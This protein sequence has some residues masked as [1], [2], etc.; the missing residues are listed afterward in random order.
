MDDGLGH[1]R[2]DR[3]P[4]QLIVTRQ[5]LA[6]GESEDFQEIEF[7]DDAQHLSIFDHGEGIEIVSVEER[8][9]SRMVVWRIT[10]FTVRVIYCSAVA[11]RKRYM[12]RDAPL[13]VGYSDFRR[14]LRNVALSIACSHLYRCVVQA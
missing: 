12:M 1:R 2:A 9:S 11:W 10:V 14:P 3:P 13:F 6:G 4:H 8:P 5:H 7:C